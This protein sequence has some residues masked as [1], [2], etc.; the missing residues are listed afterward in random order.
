MSP[1]SLS[2]RRPQPIAVAVIDK[3]PLVH[4][5]L[6]QML[7][8][9]GRF[10]LVMSAPDSDVFLSDYAARGVAAPVDVAVSGWVMPNGNDGKSLL[11][12]IFSVANPPKIVIYTG[13]L[14]EPFCYGPSKAD[15]IKRVAV[16]EGYDLDLCYAY[17]DSLSDLPMLEVVGHPVAVNPDSGLEAVAR[18]RGWPIVEFSRTARNVIRTTTAATG[19]V[20]LAIATN[21][22]GRRHGRRAAGL[23]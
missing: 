22:L 8:E 6:D 23:R 12:R 4:R 9:D 20:G 5:G 1:V 21:A 18:P 16:R 15:A 2:Q 13:E 11:R 14:S 19:A 17:S 3:N 10:E 7:R